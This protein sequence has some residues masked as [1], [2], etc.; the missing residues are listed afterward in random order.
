SLPAPQFVEAEVSSDRVHPPTEVER[1]I[2]AVHHA[3]RFHEGLLR[4]VLCEQRVAELATQEAVDRGDVASVQLLERVDVATAISADE[5]DV[6][7]V[8]A[9]L[10]RL[11][12]A[13]GW[14]VFGR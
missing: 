7:R 3:Q 9:N 5:L 2:D 13:L 8:L 12:S 11:L 14:L 10:T 6:G 4:D 1:I